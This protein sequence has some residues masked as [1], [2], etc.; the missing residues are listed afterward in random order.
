M[1]FSMAGT[2]DTAREVALIPNAQAFEDLLCDLDVWASAP[3]EQHRMLYEHFYELITDHQ[4]E[5]LVIVRRSPLLSRVLFVLFDRPH[6]LW[7]TNEIVFNLL[8]AIVQPQSDNRSMLKLGQA[9]AATLPTTAEDLAVESKL[10]FHISELQIQLIANQKPHE[11]KPSVL[12]NVY[13][14]NRLLNMIANFLSHSS[15]QLNQHMA[16]QIVRVL[17]FDWIYCLLSPEIHSGTVFLALRILL[18]LLAHPPLLVKFREG[19]ANGGWLTDADS[20]VRNRAAV[21]ILFTCAACGQGQWM[22]DMV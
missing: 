11:G 16:D 7:A 21:S 1:I 20:V 2:L 6:L 15:P 13:V 22:P 12:Y 17:G 5:N 4:R 19:T 14:R 18:A 8:S 9:I 10:P 3:D